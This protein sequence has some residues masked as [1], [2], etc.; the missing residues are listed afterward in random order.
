M[1]IAGTPKILIVDDEPI[2]VRLLEL[3][4]HN[5]YTTIT[6]RNGFDAIK[7]V[8]EQQPDLLL[9][10]IMMPDL[11]GFEVCRIIK[12]D[13]A[14]TTMP[15]I[16]VTALEKPSDESQG[17]ILGAVDYITKPINP[18][19]VR[20]RVRNHLELKF[21]R[22]TLVQQ[23]NELEETLSR[24]NRLEGIISICMY[25]KKI[26]NEE[27]MWEQMEKYITEHSDAKFSHGICPD[28]I[29]ECTKSMAL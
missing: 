2:N 25:C 1:A 22:D 15:I 4:L 14:F 8:K 3:T 23:K 11:N 9:L 28:C 26:R 12:A 18:D 24:I 13:K 29:E 19:I 21:Q 17:L 7:L 20:L 5:D 16:F 10:D 6:A 27:K